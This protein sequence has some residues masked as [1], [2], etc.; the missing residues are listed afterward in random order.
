MEAYAQEAQLPGGKMKNPQDMHMG[1]LRAAPR[2]R[3]PRRMPQR[4]KEERDR[5]SN[6]PYTCMYHSI[7]LTLQIQVE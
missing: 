5:P 1:M 6:V 3:V 2:A 7:F 4:L